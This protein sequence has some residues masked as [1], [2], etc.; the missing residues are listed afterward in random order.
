MNIQLKTLALLKEKQ[1]RRMG[2]IER[3][4]LD[5][6]L[7]LSGIPENYGEL[8]SRTKEMTCELF[9]KILKVPCGSQ[10]FETNI[11]RVGRVGTG[12]NRLDLSYPC[13]IFPLIFSLRIYSDRL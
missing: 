4:Y 10:F 13:P 12:K 5:R 8:E 9:V 11:D 7:M 1:S 3:H 2:I 6:R